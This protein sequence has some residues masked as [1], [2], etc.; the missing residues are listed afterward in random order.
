MPGGWLGDKGTRVATAALGSAIVDTYM[1]HQH[2]NSV[3]GIRHTALRQA[4]EYTI[5][6]TISGPIR[7]LAEEERQKQREESEDRHRKA[8]KGHKKGGRGKKR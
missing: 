5:K 4:A 7:H 3:N 2:P 6:N 8:K 1:S